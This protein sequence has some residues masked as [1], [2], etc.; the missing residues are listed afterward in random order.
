MKHKIRVLVAILIFIILKYISDVYFNNLPT[1][2]E[3]PSQHQSKLEVTH[4]IKA[5]KKEM[6]VL[7]F[8]AKGCLPC[9]KM[10]KTVWPHS[11]I[12]SLVS[13]YYNSPRIIEASDTDNQNDFERYNIEAVPTTVIVDSEGEQIKRSV[14]YMDVERLLDFLK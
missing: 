5:V 6:Q 11:S 12:E 8:T 7:F 10:K 13:E 2:V 4:A 3:Y 1:V 9:L 14:G